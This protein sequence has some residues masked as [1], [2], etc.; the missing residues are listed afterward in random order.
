MEIK[1]KQEL[2]DAIKKINNDLYEVWLFI[3]ESNTGDHQLDYCSDPAIVD[4]FDTT[5]TRVSRINAILY[6][7]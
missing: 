1:N 6:Q 3:N 2:K 7:E 4:I 5:F